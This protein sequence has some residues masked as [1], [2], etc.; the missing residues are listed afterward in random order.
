MERLELLIGI[1]LGVLGVIA[2][3][4]GFFSWL[5]GK[6]KSIGSKDDGSLKIPKKTLALVVKE[7]GRECWWHMGKSGGSPSMQIVAHFTAT[8]ICNLGVLPIS[9]KMRKPRNHGHVLTRKHDANI[10]GSHIIPATFITDINVDFWVTPPIK[11][12]GE[13]FK[14]NI[15][16]VDKFGHEL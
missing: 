16:I 6:F 13:T 14:A 10:Y 3:I 12:A 9:A 2:Y 1:V 15:A 8:N 11:S 7:T 4:K 5:W